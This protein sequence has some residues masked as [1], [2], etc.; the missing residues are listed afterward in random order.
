MSDEFRNGDLAMVVVKRS[1]GV[2]IKN[3]PPRLAEFHTDRDEIM[4]WDPGFDYVEPSEY[5]AFF[6]TDITAGVE[7]VEITKRVYLTDNTP[8]G[9]AQ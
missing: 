7:D 8:P 6:G 4:S 9:E 5:W 3:Q 1:W 2:T